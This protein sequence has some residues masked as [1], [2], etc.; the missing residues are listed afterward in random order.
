VAAR[1]YLYVPGDQEQR[2]AGAARRGAD[3]LVLDLEDAVAAA[4]K[5][6]ARRLVGAYLRD[7]AGPRPPVW[8]RVTTQGLEDD[9][10]A[11][12]GPGLAGLF[13]P[14]AD[15]A[16]AVRADEV[17]LRLERERGL[18]ERS[19]RLVP[20][21]E[22]AQGLHDAAEVAA[23]PRVDRLGIGEADLA[24][25]LGVLPGP[26]REEMWAFRAQ[27]VA[28]SARAGAGRPVG[29]VETALRDEDL[30][31]RSTARLLRQGFRART[32]LTPGQVAVVNRVLTPSAEEVA[33][34]RALVD[35]LGAATA[36]G[37]GVAV[38][39][40]GR[41]VDEAVVRSARDVLERAGE[42]A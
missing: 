7:D 2:L 1:T 21:V 17:L 35:A 33:R 15:A 37:T 28:A 40:D 29:P 23:H 12:V 24:A 39:A 10:A 26:E 38:D 32:C 27:V 30:L 3:A 25:D 4:R 42:D 34:A 22:S 8:V 36:S 20:L 16:Q 13:L 9:A 31:E 14:K 19:V 5:D 41:I 11:V 6:E 18:A